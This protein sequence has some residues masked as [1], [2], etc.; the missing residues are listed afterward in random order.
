MLTTS[1]L[2]LLF[3]SFIAKKVGTGCSMS[4]YKI[5]PLTNLS[6]YLQNDRSETEVDLNISVNNVSK[7]F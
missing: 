5:V 4:S 7:K 2:P 1:G 3:L 6:K